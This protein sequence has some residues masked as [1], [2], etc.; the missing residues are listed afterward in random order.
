MIRIIKTAK[1]P[2]FFI[3]PVRIHHF[4]AGLAAIA[5]GVVAVVH[6]R[7]DLIIWILHGRKA[8]R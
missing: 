5:L 2:Q 4:V 6:D 3:G 7:D 8:I 1:G